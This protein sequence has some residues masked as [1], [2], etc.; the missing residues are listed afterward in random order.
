[1]SGH[2][3]WH[4]IKHKKGAADAKRSALFTKLAH[5]VTIAARQGG[6]DIDMNP[7]LSLAVEKAKQANM[8]KDNIDRAIKRG[9]G[10]GSGNQVEEVLYEIFG[11]GGVGILVQALTNNKNRTVSNLKHI[12]SKYNSTLAAQNSV[13]WMFELKGVIRLAETEIKDRDDLEMNLIEQGILD[14][15][16][17]ENYLVIYTKMEDLQKIEAWLKNNSYQVEYAEIEWIAKE[18][19]E[20]DV[21]IEEKLN[22]LLENLDEDEDISDYYTNVK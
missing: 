2:S 18:L 7:K 11:P 20:V 13:Q 6:G 17:E 12:L 15:M 10:D 9:T 8:P 1:M 4:S 16:S 5:T 3:K 22:R 21:N 14:I 19:I